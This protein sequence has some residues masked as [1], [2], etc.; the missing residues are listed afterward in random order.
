MF[1]LNLENAEEPE[2]TL[3]TATGSQKKQKSSIKTSTSALLTMPKPLTVWITT[4]G[5]KFFKRWD[6]PDHLTC[7]LRNMYAGQE[8]TVRTGH[9]PRD[10]FK[11]GK[12]VHQGCYR[13]PAYL[14][15]MKSTS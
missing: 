11:I 7:V 3:S 2:I 10:W 14:T 5:G 15:Y 12:G 1:K 9:R 8:A 13:H 6:Y 4:N